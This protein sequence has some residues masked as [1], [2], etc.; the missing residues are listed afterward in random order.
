MR[1]IIIFILLLFI[2]LQK[3][4]P[5][6]HFL[7]STNPTIFAEIITQANLKTHVYALASPEMEGRETGTPGQRQAA[8][9]LAGIFESY[10]LPRVGNQNSYFQP[11]IYRTE[12]WDQVRLSIRG[13]LQR[14][15][16]DFYAIPYFNTQLDS[17]TDNEVLF[18]GYG[19]DEAQY[20]DYK[21]VNVQH[22]ILLLYDGEPQDKYGKYL[23][24]GTTTPS[25]WSRNW[26][27]KL[28][29]AKAKGAKA[30]FF[31]DSNFQE[32]LFRN[33]QQN[34]SGYEVQFT[35]P[36]ADTLLA[37]NIFLSS[38]LAKRLVGSSYKDVIKARKKITL[39]GKPQHVRIPCAVSIR[40]QKRI[41]NL[42]GENVLGYIE[43]T[44]EQLREELVVV[45]AHYDHLGK[46]GESIYFGADDNAS[47][48]ST[49]LEICRAFLEAKAQ[50]QGPRR[51]IL[52]MLV[53]G[54][55]KGL[56]GSKYYV[57]NPIFPLEQTI[58]N[59]NVDMV[60][61]VDEK[62]SKNADYIYVIGSDRLSTDLH[63]INEQANATYVGLE[64]DYTYNA[65]SDPSRYYY[66]SD[67][68]NFAEKG[69][70]AIFYFSG[71]HRDY[72]RTTDTPDKINYQK[73]E[74]IARL[75][76]FTTW[77]LAN[78]DERIRVDAKP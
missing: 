15:G 30:V 33:A 48:T 26:R 47:G 50:G 3:A 4:L 31:I 51:S 78:R 75:I 18:L 65:E 32:N 54:E 22:K 25:D 61:R 12:S 8:A 64:L 39:K 11:I 21:G 24:T 42:E 23:L 43:G 46:R 14:A 77:E 49:V 34:L 45:T 20:S 55:E 16:K 56:L 73:M 41:R 10:G 27:R 63:Q 19:I 72:H 53:A 66:R 44:D 13:E 74:K 5:Q 70:P 35:N 60:G 76:F 52:F 17:L 58:A 71:T 59:V 69:V 1:Y 57:E 7:P 40:L 28:T 6:G 68:Y 9:Y 62:H 37:N 29:V 67:H 36:D 38:T 2:G